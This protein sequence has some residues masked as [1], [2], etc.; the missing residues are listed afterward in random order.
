MNIFPE[1]SADQRKQL[2]G[3]SAQELRSNASDLTARAEEFEAEALWCRVQAAALNEAAAARTTAPRRV[4]ANATRRAP[5]PRTRQSSAPKP[6]EQST[7]GPPRLSEGV[8]REQLP[9]F[10][11]REGEDPTGRKRLILGVMW[12]TRGSTWSPLEVAAELQRTGLDPGIR[13]DVALTFLRRMARGDPPRLSKLG[14]GRGT[15]YELAA[16]LRPVEHQD[17]ASP[18]SQA[19]MPNEHQT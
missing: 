9:R 13:R 10:A 16:D 7:N 11:L 6:P 4:R 14:K 1:L 5:A 2:A 12:M 3:M 15:R 18:S 19:P 17:H 8:T